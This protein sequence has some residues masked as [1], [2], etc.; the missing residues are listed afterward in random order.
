MSQ[1]QYG[2]QPSYQDPATEFNGHYPPP[3]PGVALS[4]TSMILGILSLFVVGVILGPIAI[5]KGNEAERAYGVQATVGK[6][7]GMVGLILGALQLLA[8]VGYFLLVLFILPFSI[9]GSGMSEQ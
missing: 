2:P 6:V 9:Y 7:T 8:V 4:Q 3:H 5:I 1:P